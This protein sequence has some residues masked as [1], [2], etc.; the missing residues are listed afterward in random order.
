LSIFTLAKQIQNGGYIVEDKKYYELEERIKILEEKLNCISFSEAKEIKM[1]GCPIGDIQ[2]GNACNLTF[3]G[4]P[5]TAVID[6]DID[7][8][9]S[10]LDELECRLDDINSDIDDAETKL[11]DLKN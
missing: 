5:I 11:D 3:E 7:D 4:C 6:R 9:E 8:A 10:R 2:I 1:Q